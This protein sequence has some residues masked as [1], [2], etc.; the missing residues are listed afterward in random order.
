M[1]TLEEVVIADLFVHAGPAEHVQLLVHLQHFVFSGRDLVHHVRVE[2][3][4]T[5]VFGL[6]R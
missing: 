4:A 1:E 5:A 3:R 6:T 2:R